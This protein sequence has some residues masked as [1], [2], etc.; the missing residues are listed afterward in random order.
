MNAKQGKSIIWSFLKLNLSTTSMKMSHRE[1]SIDMFV[2]RGVFKNSFRS[3]F[4]LP[5]YLKQ[6]LE[7][8]KQGSVI[9]VN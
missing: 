6:V 9:A 5:A 1:P 3:T 8:L 7:Y 2:D 4:V